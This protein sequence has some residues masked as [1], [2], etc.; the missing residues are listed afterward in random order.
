MGMF[1]LNN[2]SESNFNLRAQ[3]LISVIQQGRKPWILSSLVAL[4]KSN[5]KEGNAALH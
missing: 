4:D 5:N 2:L 3:E 1:N